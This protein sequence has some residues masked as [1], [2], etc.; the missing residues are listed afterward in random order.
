VLDLFL[1]F[2]SILGPR[3]TMTRV[4][5][6]GFHGCDQSAW[7]RQSIRRHLMASQLTGSTDHRRS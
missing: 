7:Q 5:T 2:L 4:M 3:G 1:L 6:S